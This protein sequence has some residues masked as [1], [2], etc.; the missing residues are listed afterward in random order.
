MEAIKFDKVCFS[1]EDDGSETFDLTSAFSLKEID[2]SVEEGEFVAVI[3]HNGSGKS[4]LARLTNGLLTPKQG[5]I[6]VFGMDAGEEENEDKGPGVVG[7]ITN[8]G[9]FDGGNYN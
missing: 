9:S 8:G 3:G 1:Y 4:T 7:S 5:K 2:L 6:T